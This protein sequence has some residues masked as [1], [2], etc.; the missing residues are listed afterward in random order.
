MKL[1]WVLSFIVPNI[2]LSLIFFVFLFPIAILAKIS[3]KKNFLQLKNSGNSTWIE[4]TKI[5]DTKSMENPW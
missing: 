4:E 3:S 2:L 5:F 1:T